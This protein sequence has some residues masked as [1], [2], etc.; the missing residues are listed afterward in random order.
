MI[1]AAAIAGTIAV[2]A[3]KAAADSA[4]KAPQRAAGYQSQPSGGKKCADCAQFRSPD[5]CSLVQ[6]PISPT[7][8]CR[9]FR[10]KEA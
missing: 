8:W 7:G 10:A 5:G 1:N 9:L 3:G 2:V 4:N 6:G